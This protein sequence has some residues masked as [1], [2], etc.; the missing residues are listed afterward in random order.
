MDSLK[1]QLEYIESQL[2]TV[3]ENAQREA[4]FIEAANLRFEKNLKAL[5]D[6]FPEIYEKYLTYQPSDKFKLFVNPNGSANIIDYNTGV[7]M[8]NEDPEEQTATQVKKNIEHPII[9]RLDHSGVMHL[10]NQVNFTHIEL[11]QKLGKVYV[12]ARDELK[13]NYKLGASIPSKVIFGIGLGYHLL[14][15]IKTSHSGYINILEPNEDYFF[16]SLF[17]ADWSLILEEVNNQGAYLYLGIGFS[18]KEIYEQIYS[19][20]REV[21]VASVCH[22]WFYQHYPSVEVNRWIAEYKKNYHQFFAGF[23]FFDDAMIGLAHS[24]GNVANKRNFMLY[25]DDK[26]QSLA[27]VPAVIVANGPSLDS[28]I[29][30]LKSIKDKV[31][32]FACNSA[33]TALLK[34]G[35]IPDFHVALERTKAT[36]DFLK[37]NLPEEYRSKMNLL[38]T[39]VMHPDVPALFNWTGIALKPGESGTQMLQLAYYRSDQK[40]LRSLSHSNPLVGNTALSF[41]CNM[42]FRDIYLF[43]VDNGY[44][45]PEHHHSKASFYYDKK[46]ETVVEPTKIGNQIAIPGNFVDTV[47]T[48]EFM[49]VGNTQMGRLLD[50][51][52]NSEVH[53]FNCSNGAK[54]DGTIPLPADEIILESDEAAKSQAVEL[55]KQQAFTA[56]VSLESVERL[57]NIKDFSLLC[58]TMA[59]ILD[60]PYED[61]KEAQE[62]LLKSLRYLYS[63]R[64]SANHLA[65]YLLLEGEALYT[66]SILLSLLHNFGDD[67]EIIPHFKKAISIWSSFIRDCP[68][69]YEARYN[70]CR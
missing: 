57:T 35:I 14:E 25:Q 2:K 12:E 20:S 37:E 46:G 51:F 13:P 63:F 58:E 40:V 17:C 59:D 43:G 54:I 18:E 1:E 28:S 47:L 53:C 26:M 23:G 70:E 67:E 41:A 69:L 48:D 50:Q 33:S 3:Q 32:I 7:P 11:M 27:S 22:S 19:R 66:A 21:S 52:K 34:H 16:A 55:I 39:N 42:G 61:R 4:L 15:V 31:V 56:Q 38:V 6:P 30:V 29:E 44:I 5:Q 65:L 24:L 62:V 8:Y 64:N 9:G 60:E 10:E 45:D 36:Y 49:A 68:K